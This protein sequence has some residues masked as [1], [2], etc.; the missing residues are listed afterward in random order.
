MVSTQ[1]FKTW[2]TASKTVGVG[3]SPATPAKNNNYYGICI[4]L[5]NSLYHKFFTYESML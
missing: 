5:F 3:S 1:V 2:V 4:Y